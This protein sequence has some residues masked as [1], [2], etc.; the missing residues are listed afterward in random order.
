MWMT[1]VRL[2]EA[3]QEHAVIGGKAWLTEKKRQR[4]INT[5]RNSIE[6]EPTGLVVANSGDECNEDNIKPNLKRIMIVHFL[7]IFKSPELG[8]SALKIVQMHR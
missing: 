3:K 1:N 7:F 2:I 4:R 6:Y 5:L 8:V